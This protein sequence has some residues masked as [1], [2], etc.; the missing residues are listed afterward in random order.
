VTWQ[1]RQGV[2]SRPPPGNP[3]PSVGDLGSAGLGLNNG[4]RKQ[5]LSCQRE[6]RDQSWFRRPTV[7]VSLPKV[8]AGKWRDCRVRATGFL[9]LGL[10]T[11]CRDKCTRYGLYW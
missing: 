9:M 3:R 11:I 7:A 1:C 2:L 5:M 10:P 6:S 4:T 8:A